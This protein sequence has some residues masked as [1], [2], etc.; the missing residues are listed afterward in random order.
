VISDLGIKHGQ[1]NAVASVL[2]AAAEYVV[3][4]LL[5]AAGNC[6]IEY[7]SE[8]IQLGHVQRAVT[9]DEELQQLVDAL[10]P[11]LDV[12]PLTK[13]AASS[14]T[15]ARE[16][17]DTLPSAP[18]PSPPET[19]ATSKG[20]ERA[21]VAATGVAEKVP[22][23]MGGEWSCACCMDTNEGDRPTCRSCGAANTA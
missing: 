6:A 8:V 18:C 15:T 22:R 11:R 4:E 20:S 23:A 16:E 21:E 3:A 13:P 9:A 2:L 19:E 14:G 10:Q 5:E 17:V 1:A 12:A 7:R